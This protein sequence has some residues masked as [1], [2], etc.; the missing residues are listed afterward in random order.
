ML[1]KKLGFEN[2][3]IKASGFKE[4]L[5]TL[6]KDL[7]LDVISDLLGFAES[8]RKTFTAQD[9]TVKSQRATETLKLTLDFASQFDPTGLL[10]VVNAFTRQGCVSE[11]DI[12]DP[13]TQS[14]TG[15]YTY[16]YPS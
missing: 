1:V 2:T 11:K 12:V 10:G 16:N 13:Y 5:E 4:K 9:S 14:S 8:F 7:G 15:T 3:V 6:Y